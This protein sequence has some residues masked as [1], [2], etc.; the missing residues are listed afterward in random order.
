MN[1]AP[2]ISSTGR[3]MVPLSFVTDSLGCTTTWD[4]TNDS[5][6]IVYNES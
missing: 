3:T 2:Y 4:G 5:V 1:V 6:T